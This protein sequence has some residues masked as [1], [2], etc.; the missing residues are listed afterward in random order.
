MWKRA[1]EG[2]A[3]AEQLAKDIAHVPQELY[4][5]YT[6]IDY[7]FAAQHYSH[8]ALATKFPH[9]I[10][11]IVAQMQRLVADIEQLE[12][13]EPQQQLHIDFFKQYAHCLAL[14]D[15]AQLEAAWKQLDRVWMEIKYYIQIV[16]DIEY[17]YG[18]PLRTKVRHLTRVNE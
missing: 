12:G 6:V 1:V 11:A 2:N 5:H 7:D 17:G 9:E 4:N 14:T 10:G 13:L 18:D 16:H 8:V 3:V 15:I